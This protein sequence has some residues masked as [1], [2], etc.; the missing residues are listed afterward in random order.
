MKDRGKTGAFIA[1]ARKE[2]NMTQK[3]LAGMLHISDTTVSKWERGAGFPDVSLIEPLC[4]TLGITIAELFAGERSM[5]PAPTECESLLSDVVAES[6][7]QL[8]TKRRQDRAAFL[9][10]LGIALLIA[11]PLIFFRVEE[12]AR[13]R[14]T[15]TAA[16][17]GMHVSLAADWPD[18]EGK[19]TYALFIDSRRVDEGAYATNADG[20]FTL[21]GL[22]AD[23]TLHIFLAEPG[24]DGSFRLLL[25]AFNGGMPILLEKV[26]DTPIDTGNTYG[27][28]EAYRERYL[29]ATPWPIP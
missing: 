13:M 8:R 19:G 6:G 3:A 21:S 26:S 7:H 2:K 1:A 20:T 12:P 28:E 4:S 5:S 9:L 25:P 29:S 17:N 22:W 18:E 14:G 16:A 27:D 10:A 23:G 24:K 11:I 15:Y